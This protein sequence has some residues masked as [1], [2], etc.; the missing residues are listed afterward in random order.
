MEFYLPFFKYRPV[1]GF[2]LIKSWRVIDPEGWIRTGDLILFSGSSFISSGIKFFTTSRW[3]H[4]G[5]ACWCELTD[6]HGDKR[7]D[8]FCFELGSQAF[9]DLI[10]KRPMC[11]GV[12]LARVADITSMYDIV[13]VRKLNR[14]NKFSTFDGH[15]WAA[16]FEAFAM[17]WSQTPYF[18]TSSVIRTYLFRS[19]SPKGG[20][21][22][23]HIMAKMLDEMGVYPLDFD[24]AQVYPDAFTAA[25]MAFPAE[26]FDGPERVVYRDVTKINTRLIFLVVVL[27]ILIII[28]FAIY[29]AVGRKS[30]KNSGHSK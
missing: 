26:I 25:G 5:A 2:E 10:T 23:A 30:K 27:I 6:I 16:K 8:L 11:L 4:C 18:D 28:F 9:V 24:A 3:N 15:G 19:E 1:K 21:T 29:V 22:C 12:R 7:I 20:S 14:Q 13:A 17:R